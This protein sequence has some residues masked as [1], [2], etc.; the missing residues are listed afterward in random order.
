L[1]RMINPP[2]TVGEIVTTGT[3]TRALLVAAGETW[4]TELP[5]P[6]PGSLQTFVIFREGRS[7]RVSC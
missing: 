6:I 4:T 1:P 7:Q 3:L 5:S 2:L